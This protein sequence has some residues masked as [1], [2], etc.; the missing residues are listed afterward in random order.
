MMSSYWTIEEV[1]A[2]RTACTNQKLLLF[3][4]QDES[5]GSDRFLPTWGNSSVS[6][7]R[8]SLVC[9]YYSQRYYVLGRRQKEVSQRTRR[10]KK[11]KCHSCCV[12]HTNIWEVMSSCLACQRDGGCSSTDKEETRKPTS[13]APTPPHTIRPN[14][15][16]KK[17]PCS[18]FALS[19]QCLPFRTHQSKQCTFLVYT[20]TQ[21]TTNSIE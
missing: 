13:M 19:F 16:Q 1:R 20:H 14:C 7:S 8:E 12:L 11:E 10:Y 17:N 18:N 5:D 3:F 15:P 21:L 9:V 4:F 2:H 6:T